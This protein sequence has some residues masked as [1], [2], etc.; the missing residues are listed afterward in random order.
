MSSILWLSQGEWTSILYCPQNSSK[1]R[2]FHL[3]INI[4]TWC[5]I[6]LWQFYTRQKKI[7][8]EQWCVWHSVCQT[9]RVYVMRSIQ[10][11]CHGPEEFWR[12]SDPLCACRGVDHCIHSKCGVPW[13]LQ[14]HSVFIEVWGINVQGMY[15]A[16]LLHSQESQTNTTNSAWQNF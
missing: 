9:Y 3:V 16:F 10:H 6:C 4:S 8:I 2:I 11:M 1:T 12:A 7:E 14:A 15:P 13:E 5:T